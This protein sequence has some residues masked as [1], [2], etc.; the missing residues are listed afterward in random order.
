VAA[1]L[2]GTQAQQALIIA[3]SSL[4]WA[5]A[6]DEAVDWARAIV[7]LLPSA[8]DPGETEKLVAAIA[9]PAAAGAATEVLVD[10]LR[11][12]HSDTPVKEAGMAANLAWIAEKYPSQVRRPICPTPPQPTSLSG[13]KCPLE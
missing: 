1:K 13:L 8:Q 11:A 12:R 5:A 10:A 2:T 9:Y 6:E 3:E 7:A 4:A